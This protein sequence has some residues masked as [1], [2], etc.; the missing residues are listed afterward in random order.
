MRSSLLVLLLVSA[1]CVYAFHPPSY[2]TRIACTTTRP[3]R[4]HSTVSSRDK[5][6]GRAF[7]NMEFKRVVREVNGEGDDESHPSIEDE[8]LLPQVRTIVRAADGRKAGYIHVMRIS[9]QTEVATFMLVVEAS[10]RPQ[11]QA[12]A[13]AIEDDVILS[14]SEEV[15]SKEGTAAS[16]WIVL[17]YG[18]Y[19]QYCVYGG[20]LI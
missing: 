7:Q 8:P 2:L 9:L 18:N 17:D 1:L 13:N 12:I 4:L 3:T 15:F 20:W 14:H 10:S 11:M 16:G 6:L 19:I 5:M